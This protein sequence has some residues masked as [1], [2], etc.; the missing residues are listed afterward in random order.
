MDLYK[1]ILVHYDT[2]ADRPQAWEQAQR[3]AK[4]SGGSITLM[5][6]IEE[7]PVFLRRPAMGLPSIGRIG[8]LQIEGFED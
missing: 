5:D 1:K 7:V 3:L 6:V 8:E 2:E 4:A